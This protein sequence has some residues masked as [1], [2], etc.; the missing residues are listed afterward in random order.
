MSIPKIPSFQISL[1]LLRIFLVLCK[2]QHATVNLIM[3]SKLSLLVQYLIS[4]L[5][6][7][8]SYTLLFFWYCIVSAGGISITSPHSLSNIYLYFSRAYM[9]ICIAFILSSSFAGLSVTP[10]LFSTRRSP[11]SI[12][13]PFSTLK[14]EGEIKKSYIAYLTGNVLTTKSTIIQQTVVPTASNRE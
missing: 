13:C 3:S 7:S 14:W 5:V 8:S 6:N 1:Q 2:T 12:L 9:P 11:T 10:T 4:S